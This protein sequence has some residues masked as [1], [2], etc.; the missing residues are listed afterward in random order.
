VFGGVAEPWRVLALSESSARPERHDLHAVFGEGAGAQP[1][2]LRL[3]AVASWQAR[4]S[5]DGSEGAMKL[6]SLESMTR[7]LPRPKL[8]AWPELLFCRRMIETAVDAAKKLPQ[9]RTARQVDDG[10]V[11]LGWLKQYGDWRDKAEFLVSFDWCVHWWLDASN[12]QQ[13]DKIREHYLQEI[14]SE[15]ERARKRRMRELRKARLS[16]GSRWRQG[17]LGF[18]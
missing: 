4:T 14:D 5:T 12:E 6:S 13:A 2:R 11:A 9:A 10:I 1:A 16:N 15:F 17:E 3:Q 7:V 18:E 8:M